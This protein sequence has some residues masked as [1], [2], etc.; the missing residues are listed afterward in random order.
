MLQ[1]SIW[2][3]AETWRAEAFLGHSGTK[4]SQSSRNEVRTPRNSRSFFPWHRLTSILTGLQ[5]TLS[6]RQEQERH[7]F[8]WDQ[9]FYKLHLATY[10]G[11]IK[12]Q[13]GVVGTN[14]PKC[15][16]GWPCFS[17]SLEFSFLPPSL[18][19]TFSPTTLP[20]LFLSFPSPPLSLFSYFG[21]LFMPLSKIS[22]IGD[23]MKCYQ[24]NDIL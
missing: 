19:P 22:R 5:E 13:N 12:I 20:S 9:D 21:L 16:F 24:D 18:S 7:I 14:M 3:T 6:Q 23:C 17:I 1:M 15:A 4:L 2:N 11:F 8:G 10:Q